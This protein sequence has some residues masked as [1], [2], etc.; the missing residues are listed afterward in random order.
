M[1]TIRPYHPSDWP[2]LWQVLHATFAA[3]DTYAFAPDAP[4]AT[5]HQAWVEAAA[6]TWVACSAQGQL[7]GTYYLKPNQM[8]LGNHVANAGYVVAPQA[9][10]Q[11]VA[12]AMCEHSQQQALAL[13]FS[14]MQ[15]N[16]VVS[17]NEGAVRLWQRHGFAIVGTVPK[18]FRHQRLGL[19]DV[20]VMHKVLT[21][22]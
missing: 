19:V 13:G 22:A 18:V 6:A 3:G 14:M 1:L 4:A 15:F 16:D 17:T 12:G 11:G 9:R 2:D 8:G 20:H 7:L 10:G 5:V 21:A